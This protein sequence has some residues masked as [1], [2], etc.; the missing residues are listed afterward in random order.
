MKYAR[1]NRKNGTQHENCC[2]VGQFY[3]PYCVS[4]TAVLER[5]F[6]IAGGSCN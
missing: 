6:R 4:L 5:Y 1:S 3:A 2:L